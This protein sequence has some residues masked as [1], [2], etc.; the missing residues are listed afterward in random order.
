MADIDC[1]DGDEMAQV[2]WLIVLFKH[3]DILH[4][5]FL[6]HHIESALCEHIPFLDI[7]KMI[8]EYNLLDHCEQKVY[9]IYG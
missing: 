6:M 1:N 3:C 7:E 5:L 9:W 2:W 8:F 4:F